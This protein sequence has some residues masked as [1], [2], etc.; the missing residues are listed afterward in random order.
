MFPTTPFD[1]RQT[2]VFNDPNFES[3]NDRLQRSQCGIIERPFSTILLHDRWNVVFNYPFIRSMNDRLQR[4]CLGIVGRSFSRSYFIIVSRSGSTIVVVDRWIIV[5]SD[6]L[7]GSLIR[8]LQRCPRAMVELSASTIHLYDCWRLGFTS[9]VSRSLN[10]RFQPSCLG[11]VE[12][13]FQWS[14]FY[15][16]LTI[17][18]NVFFAIV[19]RS[20]S[21]IFFMIVG[22]LFWTI[23]VGGRWAILFN[24]YL[25]RSLIDHLHRLPCTIVEN[26][27]WR[28]LNG[29]FSK[30]PF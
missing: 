29:C 8:H 26:Q 19:Q 30:I 1:D 2:I 12:H 25:L 11:I 13:Y 6:P 28:S 20:F 22:P 14:L 17:A 27:C 18:F 7:L 10:D 5:F 23:L 9:I 16:R 3:L 15:D 24:D 21:T 4:V